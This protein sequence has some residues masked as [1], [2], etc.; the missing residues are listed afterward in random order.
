V[1]RL[2]SSAFARGATIAA[3]DLRTGHAAPS[4]RCVCGLYACYSLRRAAFQAA[5]DEAVFGAVIGWGRMFLHEDG[6]SVET[7]AAEFG[8][9]GTALYRA[10]G[11]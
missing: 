3:C 9:D 5:G 4:L 10:E 1:L 6:S 8:V 7:Y 2:R 11:S